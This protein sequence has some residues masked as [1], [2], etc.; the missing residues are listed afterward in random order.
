[1]CS[2]A[3]HPIGL[4]SALKL[5]ANVSLMLA[6]T[7]RNFGFVRPTHSMRSRLSTAS[8]SVAGPIVIRT[9]EPLVPTLR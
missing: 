1:M 3:D 8:V 2:N 5:G 9:E 4:I 6:H 7:S